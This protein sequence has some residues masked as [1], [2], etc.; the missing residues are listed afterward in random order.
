M[1]ENMLSHRNIKIMLNTDYREIV[2]I[3]PYREMI[4]P[5]QLMNSSITATESYRTA[6]W[7]Q[8]WNAQHARASTSGS[9]ELSQWAFVYP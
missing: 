3:I 4:Y 1:F 8:A 9:R 7:V 2:G 6:L 5:D